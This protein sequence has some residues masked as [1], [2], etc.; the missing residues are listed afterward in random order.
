MISEHCPMTHPVAFHWHC[1]LLDP[2]AAFLDWAS[3]AT[4]AAADR[5]ARESL[6]SQIF[7]TSLLASRGIAPPEPGLSFV[8]GLEALAVA[9]GLQGLSQD[10]FFER[11]SP[12]IRHEAFARDVVGIARLCLAHPELS[13]YVAGH[14]GRSAPESIKQQFTSLRAE[15]VCSELRDLGARHNRMYMCGC[16]SV[17]AERDI[18]AA[19]GGAVDFSKAE[20]RLELRSGPLDG[21]SLI[22]EWGRKVW[23]EVPNGPALP[24]MEY[25]EYPPQITPRIPRRGR[26]RSASE[27]GASSSSASESV[28]S[29]SRPWSASM[30]S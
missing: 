30:G 11:A 28:A 14:C 7:L 9:E 24:E 5:S 18:I 2:V 21:N 19:G 23:Q 29:E 3:L 15:S 10:I 17:V 8:L 6:C 1:Q 16:S 13:V 26:P 20:V 22:L 12:E 27:S 25:T 4:F